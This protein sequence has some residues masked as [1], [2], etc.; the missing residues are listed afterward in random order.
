MTDTELNELEAKA[1]AATQG[2]WMSD[3]YGVYTQN[4]ISLPRNPEDCKYIAAANPAVILELITELKQARK[5]RDWLAETCAFTLYKITNK[6]ISKGLE[7][8]YPPTKKEL[9]I[10]AKEATLKQYS[11]LE[12]CNFTA[13]SNSTPPKE[14]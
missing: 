12:P 10:E 13:N 4:G 6:L 9:L 3:Y 7:L 1:K 11:A 8:S 5:E 2:T 14:S